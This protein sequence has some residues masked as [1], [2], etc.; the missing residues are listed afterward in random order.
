VPRVAYS[1]VRLSSVPSLTTPPQYAAP[2]TVKLGSGLSKVKDAASRTKPH[3]AI[4]PQ[5]VSGP[6][7]GHAARRGRSRH[8]ADVDEHED[9]GRAE[10]LV[11]PAESPL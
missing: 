8:M 11:S 7:I 3:V 4:G 9:D 1:L 10:S 5:C 6:V 2:V